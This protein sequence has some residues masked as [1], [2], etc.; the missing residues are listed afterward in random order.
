MV[1]WFLDGAWA[2][3]AIGSGVRRL[4]TQQRGGKRAAQTH[5]AL[6]LLALLGVLHLGAVGHT[7]ELHLI[8]PLPVVFLLPKKRGPIALGLSCAPQ[9]PA[10]TTTTHIG[11]YTHVYFLCP[12]HLLVG[13]GDVPASP[14]AYTG[15]HTPETACSAE[16]GLAATS[17]WGL[18][19]LPLSKSCI[20]P[21]ALGCAHF[22]SLGLMQGKVRCRE[23][24]LENHK[25]QGPNLASFMTLVTSLNHLSHSCFDYTMGK[26]TGAASLWVEWNP[27][28]G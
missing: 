8:H 1:L 3:P 15:P 14:A 27:Q 20:S 4:V 6:Q 17:E 2:A 22:I 25:D 11:T 28:A 13:W 5:P 24:G 7:G 10:T 18:E 21:G 26:P 23:G 12:K 19:V 16:T 9:T